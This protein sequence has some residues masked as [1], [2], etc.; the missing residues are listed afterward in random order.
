MYLSKKSQ[1]SSVV[2][3][4]ATGWISGGS[5]SGTFWEFFSLP[6]RPDRLQGPP[7]LL[8]NGYEGFFP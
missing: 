6:R 4:W 3:R 7:S 1:A 5:S 2:Q 8:S